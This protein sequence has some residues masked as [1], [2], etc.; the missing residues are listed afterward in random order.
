MHSN[1]QQHRSI[2]ENLRSSSELGISEPKLESKG[3]DSFFQKCMLS[4]FGIVFALLLIEIFFRVFSGAF[5]TSRPP[6]DVPE[7]DYIPEQAFRTRDFYY[8]PEKAAGVFR[9]IVVGDSFTFGGKVHF[10]DTFPKRLERML[11]LN[12]D[13]RKVEVLNW[14]IPGYSTVQEAELIKE[15]LKK[16]QPDLIV[17]E[18]TLNDAEQQPYRVT[19]P[20]QDKSGQI[21]L[22][23]PIFKLWKSLGFIV[24]RV[25]NSILHRE[26]VQYHIDLFENPNT[27]RI[28]DASLQHIATLSK[29]SNVPIFALVFPMLSHPFDDSYPFAGIHRKIRKA[30]RAHDLP[31]IDLFENFRGRNPLRLQVAPGED[32]HPNELAHR[33]AADRLYKS[34]ARRRVLPKDALIKRYMRK[35]IIR[36]TAFRPVEAKQ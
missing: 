24:T 2:D 13:Q 30:L 5:E 1:E 7:R 3:S 31:R 4:V 36:P 22:K 8:P 18:I 17:L 16:F 20:F 12:S 19:H 27:W 9:I 28:F 23:N 6:S 34:L 21:K 26:Y 33:I 35:S 25:Y 32:A 29:K 15:G 11:N 14:G 10:D